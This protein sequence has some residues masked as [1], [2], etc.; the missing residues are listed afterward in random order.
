MSIIIKGK[1]T[2][3][4][5]KN[6]NYRILGFSPI[7]S[8]CN[9]VKI[10]MYGNISLVGE[11]GY[12]NVNEDY[13][14]KIEEKSTDKYGTSYTVLSVPSLAEIDLQSLSREE[15]KAILMTFTTENQANNILDAYP[16]FIDKVVN[17]GEESIDVK[18]IYGVGKVYL[19]AYVRELNER[20]KYVHLIKKYSDYEVNITD[21]KTLYD[22]YLTE[23]KIEEAF[24]EPY[25]VLIEI[26]GRGFEKAD[27]LLCKVRPELIES[28]QR[29]EAMIMDVLHNNENEGSSRLKGSELW[30][31]CQ[32]YDNRLLPLVK[33]VCE[34]SKHI[35][36]NNE[37]KDIAIMETY[38][39]EVRVAN[40]IKD[41]V[42]NSE[43]LDFDWKKYRVT[44][45]GFE[46]NDSQLNVLK[47]FCESGLSIVKGYSG[48]GKTFS[49]KQLIK[50]LDDYHMTYTLL[51]PTGKSARV[52]AEQTNRQAY[53]IHKKCFEGDITTDVII[54][55]ESG[56]VGLEVMNMLISACTNEKSRFVFVG[57]PAQIPSISL[58]KIYEDMIKSEIVPSSNLT[59]VFRYKSNGSLFVATNVRQGK[60]F[61]KD[62]E[63]VKNNGKSYTVCDNYKFI[64]TDEDD[65]AEVVIN[66][67]YKLLNKG[68]KPK[69]ILILAPQNVGEIGTYAINNI[70]QSEVNPPKANEVIMSRRVGG[71]SIKFRVGDLVINTKN[72]YKA[73]SYE[74]YMKLK[75]DCILTEQD[76]CDKIVVN[77]Q[78]GIIREVL[79]KEG[80]LVQFDEDLIFMNKGKLNQLLLG[81]SI[82]T[83]KAQGSTTEYTINIISSKHKRLLS[84]GLLY[85][86]DT[87]NKKQCVDIGSIDAYETAL[88]IN[89]NDT[90]N[91]FLLELLTQNLEKDLTN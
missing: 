68:I 85:V 76:V 78:I 11:L 55:D 19:K 82:S 38:L 22:K 44:D 20:Y 54:V 33:D 64:E 10:N 27:K 77:G 46:L 15:S 80:L 60:S 41:K 16:N 70:I 9:K 75:E 48:C 31:F 5:Y 66:E 1:V 34:N 87:R 63:M 53:T 3:E 90:R 24:N 25:F 51:A 88:N 43:K 56:M 8:D 79:D 50:M 39:G 29:C 7:S 26:L 40:F 13:E 84:R 2:K 58:G 14:I 6:G 28:N 65:I 74:A 81:Y 52:L 83:F 23:E 49:V 71:T 47:V 4:V 12:L 91:T 86:A 67:Y 57:D 42:N 17:E 62:T 35:Y 61:F 18:K 59:E 37:T 36:Y 45:D 32:E 73:V 21:C 30:K 69:D 72:D 89:I